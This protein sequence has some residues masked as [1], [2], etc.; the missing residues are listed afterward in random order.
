VQAQEFVLLR[1]VFGV[2]VAEAEE[3]PAWEYRMLV[4]AVAPQKEVA[5][6]GGAFDGVPA[7][8]RDLPFGG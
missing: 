2:S 6:A 7:G 1:R 5:P 8:V 4:A 3:M